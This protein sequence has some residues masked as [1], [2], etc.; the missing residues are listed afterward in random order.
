MRK[1]KLIPIFCMLLLLITP[2]LSMISAEEIKKE[3]PTPIF[4]NM[5]LAHITISGNGTSLILSS[6]LGSGFGTWP[7]MRFKMSETGHIEINK[8]LNKT[9]QV[10]LDGVHVVNIIGFIG[11]YKKNKDNITLNGFAAIVSWR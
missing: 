1:K 10:I 9:N 11:Y 3:E 5:V 8:F 7:Y 2:S 4:E 6:G